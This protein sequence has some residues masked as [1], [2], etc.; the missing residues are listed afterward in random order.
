MEQF[1]NTPGLIHIGEMIFEQLNNKSLESCSKVCLDWKKMLD[2]PRTWLNI[3]VKRAPKFNEISEH[4][5]P[6]HFNASNI[7]IKQWTK[8][9]SEPVIE[10]EMTNL[11]K[12][13][14]SDEI[15]K[16][17]RPPIYMA[18][19]VKDIPLIR[20]LLLTY[21]NNFLANGKSKTI[22]FYD[23]A[24]SSIS[25]EVIENLVSGLQ[26]K[27]EL[28]TSVWSWNLST[29]VKTNPES[30]NFFKF[31]LEYI[32]A[33]FPDENYLSR[34]SFLY[35]LYLPLKLDSRKMPTAKIAQ[36]ILDNVTQPEKFHYGIH[37]YLLS[38][39]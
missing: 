2:N 19:L 31:M 38:D 11:L 8:L 37:S 1:F 24:N 21:R 28:A 23:V 5:K 39:D 30:G 17:F 3:C 15:Q 9:I 33:N 35:Y 22:S 6:I 18:L 26:H 27:R 36:E 7:L 10:Y 4:L 29:A 20:H 12:K 25:A 13:M 14:H 32:V 34:Y 16:S